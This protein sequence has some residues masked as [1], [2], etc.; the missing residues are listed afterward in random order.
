MK[1]QQLE[2][3]DERSVN[4]RKIGTPNIK[5]RKYKGNPH[6]KLKKAKTERGRKSGNCYGHPYQLKNCEP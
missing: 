3:L 2:V 4:I 5:G 1:K 6:K